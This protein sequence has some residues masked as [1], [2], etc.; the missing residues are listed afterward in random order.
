V[1]IDNKRDYRDAM[2]DDAFIQQSLCGHFG[3]E[4]AVLDTHGELVVSVV[5]CCRLSVPSYPVGLG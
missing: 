2:L 5:G 1:K 3:L 4:A